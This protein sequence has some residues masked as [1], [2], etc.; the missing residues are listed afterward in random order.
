MLFKFSTPLGLK[1]KLTFLITF[2]L[3]VG[4]KLFTIM[5]NF[6]PEPLGQFQPASLQE[7]DLRGFF[8]NKGLQPFPKENNSSIVK[9]HWWLF[10]IFFFRT[11]EPITT[12]LGTIH[13]Q[14]KEIQVCSIEEHFQGDL[15]QNQFQ[16]ILAQN[17][18][19]LRA[20]EGSYPFQIF[21][22]EKFSDNNSDV[23]EWNWLILGTLIDIYARYCTTQE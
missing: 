15:L 19:G 10:K 8:S 1:L 17:I 2:C 20:N 21:K 5:I 6:S 13:L 22:G 14:V 4:Q 12:K 7:G 18:L 3:P 9:L 11:T 16:Q 23:F